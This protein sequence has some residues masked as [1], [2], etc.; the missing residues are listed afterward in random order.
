VV[1]LVAP[2][3]RLPVGTE[4][5]IFVC[6]LILTAFVGGAPKPYEDQI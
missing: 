2:P 4:D 6:Y 5:W 1:A 3:T